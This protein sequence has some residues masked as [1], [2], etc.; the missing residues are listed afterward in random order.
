ML[1]MVSR[2]QVRAEVIPSQIQ[3]V[4]FKSVTE[5]VN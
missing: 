2:T 4:S 1:E 3:E 5:F